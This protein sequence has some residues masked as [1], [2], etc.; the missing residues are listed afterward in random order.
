ME[1]KNVDV[2]SF[3]M[4]F[5]LCYKYRECIPRIILSIKK[6]YKVQ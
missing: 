4:L 5:I 2:V 3:Y 1:T 6:N